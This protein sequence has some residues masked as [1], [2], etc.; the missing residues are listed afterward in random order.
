MTHNTT[1]THTQKKCPENLKEASS[2][3]ALRKA[4]Y[5]ES[6]YDSNA[7]SNTNESFDLWFLPILE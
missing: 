4:I 5:R 7:R 2:A 6:H 3:A 1:D